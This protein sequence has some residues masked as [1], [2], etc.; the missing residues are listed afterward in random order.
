MARL[1]AL[2]FGYS[3]RG[4]RLKRSAELLPSWQVDCATNSLDEAKNCIATY[5]AHGS[6]ARL[7]ACKENQ[8][9]TELAVGSCRVTSC[10][11]P[12]SDAAQELRIAVLICWSPGCDAR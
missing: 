10:A 7:E 11:V 6:K 1:G 4:T 2:F 12:F 5:T 3:K 9:I 8:K